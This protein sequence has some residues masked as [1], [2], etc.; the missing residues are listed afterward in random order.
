MQ[1]RTGFMLLV[2]S[3]VLIA[4]GSLAVLPTSADEATVELVSFTNDAYGI[5]GVAPAGWEEMEEGYFVRGSSATD[6][7]SLTYQ[8]FPTM[9]IDWATSSLILPE[10]GLAAMPE[11][12]GSLETPAFTWSLY[13]IELATNGGGTAVMD[14]ALAENESGVYLVKF[15][16]G[17]DEYA[18]LHEAVFLPAV[19]A[20]ETI[21]TADSDFS[22]EENRSLFDYDPSAPLDIQEEGSRRYRYGGYTQTNFT[23]AS[24]KGGRVPATIYAPDGE[25]PFAGII[26]M[27]GSGG[28]QT[29]FYWLAKSY[30]VTGAVV[31]LITAPE[32][33][34]GGAIEIGAPFIGIWNPEQQ[35]QLIVDLRR[36][37]DLLIARPDV[38]PGRLGYI[39]FSYGGA[40][41]GLLAGVENRLQAYSLMS[42][43]G[44]WITHVT[45]IE[46][47]DGFLRDCLADVQPSLGLEACEDW[48][49]RMHPIES[50]R[51][52]HY[53]APAALLFQSGLRDQMVPIADAVPYQRAGSEPKTILWYDSEHQLPAQAFQDQA[54]WLQQYIGIDAASFQPPNPWDW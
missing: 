28:N 1:K 9:T 11:S 6:G 31:M 25:G 36:A 50:W 29:D 42:G 23:Y 12:G 30:V 16:S 14:L 24:P 34:P 18:S 48:L 32:S 37:V 15:L 38:D 7:V 2:F 51:F 10:L 54:E 33:R 22:Y 52:V 21:E 39:G 13:S 47:E 46:G 17:G 43:D 3:L 19:E 4:Q 27:H 49:A 20:L 35:I 53:A 40:Q 5:Q 44:G 41:G 8:F 26:I 45:G